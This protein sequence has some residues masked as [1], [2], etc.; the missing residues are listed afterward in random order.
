MDAMRLKYRWV[1]V[2][3]GK[4]DQLVKDRKLHFALLQVSLPPTLVM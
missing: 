4:I 2:A 3:S 1:L